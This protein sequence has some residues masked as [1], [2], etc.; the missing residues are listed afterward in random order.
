MQLLKLIFWVPHSDYPNYLCVVHISYVARFFL[1]T[2]SKPPKKSG[3]KK[4]YRFFKNY[5]RY[6]KSN[7]LQC[8]IKYQPN[9]LAV[10]CCMNSM[11]N[12]HSNYCKFSIN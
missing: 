10:Y 12:D 5:I 6:I 3:L 2:C 4:Q 11:S 9:I 7:I 8:N 1:S